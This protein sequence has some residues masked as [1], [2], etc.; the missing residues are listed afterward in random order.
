M[1]NK[2]KM[3]K[4]YVV[5]PAYNEGENIKQV[6]DDWYPVVTKIGKDSRLVI[7]NDGSKDNT[8]EII[9][10]QK[11]T[12]C[13]LIHIVKKNGGH[14]SAIL[15]GY[16]FAISKDADFIFQTDSDRQTEPKEF[17]K[18]WSEKDS[19]DIVLATRPVRGDGK[20]RK[21]VEN[22]VCFLLRLIFGIRVEDANAPFRL[23]RA[24]VVNKYINR[25]P[26]DFNI[27]N[28]MFTTYFIYYGEKVKFLPIT[29]KQR[30][31]GTNSI[32][33]FKITKIGW[34]ALKDFIAL[35]VKM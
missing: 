10:N 22:V 28:I 19:Y 33:I 23:M 1:G 3:E 9:E 21:F 6:I 30:Q 34:K 18:F 8:G 16:Q 20:T 2:R 4:L 27:P 11:E 7:V 15:Y 25:L 35:R 17:W 32:N 24:S 14:G 13:Q 12:H 5:I 31:G 26:E 29:F